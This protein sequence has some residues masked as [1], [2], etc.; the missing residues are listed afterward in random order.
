MEIIK[1][2]NNSV[3]LKGK[4]ATLV[5]DPSGKVD[6]DI[7]LVSSTADSSA[8]SK[9]EGN[10]LIISGPGEYEAGGISITAKAA[11]GGVIYYIYDNVKILFTLSSAISSVPDDEDFDCLLVKIVGEIPKDAF[12][13]IQAKC[14]VLFGDLALSQMK[15][16]EI[17][18]SAKINLKKTAEVQGKTFIVA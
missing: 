14:V 4:N 17:E 5:I 15:S 3:K 10:R 13:P 16:E 9:I 18:S 1:N 6:A 7:V 12:G 8:F 11:K 2:S